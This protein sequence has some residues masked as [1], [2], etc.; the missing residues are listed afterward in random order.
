MKSFLSCLLALVTSVL[1]SWSSASAVELLI[2]GDFETPQGIGDIPGWELDEFFTGSDANANTAEITGGEDQ[3]LWLRPFVSGPIAAEFGNF[4]QV[5]PDDVDGADFLEYQKGNSPNGVGATDLGEWQANYGLASRFGNAV[6]TQVVSASPGETYNFSGTST[7][8]DNY[9]GQVATLDADGPFGAIASPTSNTLRMEFL[10]AGGAVI[11]THE[12]DVIDE[13]LN[14]GFPTL[15]LEHTP[16]SAVAPT[17][18]ANV[19][20]TAEARDMAWNGAGT[21]PPGLLQSAFYNDLSLT[22]QSDPSTELLTNGGLDEDPPSA[23]DFWDLQSDP[24]MEENDEI[25]RTPSAAWANN[26]PGGTR[27][28]W[29]SAFFGAN[30][31]FDPDPVDGTMSQTVAAQPGL[32]Y[33]FSGATRF[34]ANYSGGFETIPDSGNPD[35]FFSGLASPTRT[36]IVLEFLDSN[37]DVIESAT[38]DVREDRESIIGCNTDGCANDG[39]WYTHT[40]QAIAPAGTVEARL[41]GQMIDG[42]HSGF[43]P[44]SAF[45]DDFSLDDGT[46]AS[47]VATVPEPTSGLLLCV[48]SLLLG[49]GRKRRPT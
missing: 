5:K 25:L 45:F 34:E 9:S 27:G 36:E 47:L 21:D 19:R 6:L 35:I 20:V 28:V 41:T 1:L 2:S 26:T 8:E 31:I 23:L 37:G 29:L 42:V 12:L 22:A 14:F 18:T 10:D 46:V 43:N 40:L 39:Q 44:Q 4:D 17:G 11:G 32:T 16:I 38:I 3:R 13:Q 30:A 33:T 15:P 49:I 7:F 48:G 24:P